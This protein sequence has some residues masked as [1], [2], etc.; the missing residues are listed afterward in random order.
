MM[1]AN[2]LHTRPMR[3]A[4]ASQPPCGDP[5]SREEDMGSCAPSRPGVAHAGT[6]PGEE[7]AR[8]P[9]CSDCDTT[10]TVVALSGREV[11]CPCG[12]IFTPRWPEEVEGAA[13]TPPAPSPAA[14]ERPEVVDVT[15]ARAAW[16]GVA[17]DLALARRFVEHEGRRAGVGPGVPRSTLGRLQ[18]QAGGASRDASEPQVRTLWGVVQ[19]EGARARADFLA[20]MERW[21]EETTPR[22]DD[23]DEVDWSH[24]RRCAER[25]HALSSR[26]EARLL[27]SLASELSAGASWREASLR[28][29]DVCAPTALRAAWDQRAAEER[30]IVGRPR[31]DAARAPLDVERAAWGEVRLA[32]AVALWTE[33]G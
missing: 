2:A 7:S 19:R 28:A 14:W 26:G 8:R 20:T 12:V 10:A 18:G 9:G 31:R 30:G 17:R 33:A 24:A 22:V 15:A 13:E 21:L 29:A 27:V 5:Y 25:L 32:A 23:E 4:D 11:R 6:P 1:R 16:P 3:R